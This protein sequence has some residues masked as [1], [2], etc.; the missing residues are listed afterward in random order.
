MFN[1]IMRLDSNPKK[2]HRYGKSKSMIV[3]VFCRLS[4]IGESMKMTEAMA[5]A[6]NLIFGTV[7]GDRFVEFCLKRNI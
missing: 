7:H 6:D 1:Q 4:E 5:L 3:D 2:I